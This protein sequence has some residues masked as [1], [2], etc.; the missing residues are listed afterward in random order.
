MKVAVWDTYVNKNDGTIM[1]FDIIVPESSQDEDVFRFGEEYLRL[2]GLTELKIDT[3]KC[4]FCHVEHLQKHMERDIN[5]RG[6]YILE[7]KGC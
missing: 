3:K 5:E 1:H 7:M 6:Y 2:K 4:S